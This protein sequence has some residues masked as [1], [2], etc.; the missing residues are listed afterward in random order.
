MWR[1]AGFTRTRGRVFDA[2]RGQA[3]ASSP[4]GGVPIPRQ[5]LR[6]VGQGPLRPLLS[7]CQ[8]KKKAFVG[9]EHAGERTQ[10]MGQNPG[11]LTVLQKQT[12]EALPFPSH[13]PH[14][15]HPPAQAPGHLQRGSPTSSREGAA[16]VSGPAVG[17]KVWVHPL[18]AEKVGVQR[19]HLRQMAEHFQNWWETRS[20]NQAGTPANGRNQGNFQAEPQTREKRVSGPRGRA[21][22]RQGVRGKGQRTRVSPEGRGTAAKPEP[23]A[24]EQRSSLHA[25]YTQT[26]PHQTEK[27]AGAHG[28]AETREERR[29]ENPTHTE[30]S[31]HEQQGGGRQRPT[32]GWSHG[33]TLGA[34]G[35]VGA[36]Q[37]PGTPAPHRGGG[38]RQR[39]PHRLAGDQEEGPQGSGGRCG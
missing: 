26:G 9:R 31:P 4:R 39:L 10:T 25:E 36:P 33:G 19:Q 35:E 6:S 38:R 23:R 22:C 16:C 3:P 7:F 30:T 2:D 17:S 1:H 20:P 5:L 11:H 15:L 27:A 21:S 8:R 13:P 14:L 32:C 37:G 12:I 34:G 28:E 18:P 29:A 24:G